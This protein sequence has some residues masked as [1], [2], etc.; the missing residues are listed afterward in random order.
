[1]LG[2]RGGADAVPD[3]TRLSVL[4]AV[5]YSDVKE[6]RAPGLSERSRGNS[7]PP[8]RFRWR[9][10][11]TPCPEAA[12]S[13]E[14]GYN[15]FVA[16]K[17]EQRKQDLARRHVSTGAMRA[18][19]A[20]E[21]ACAE[22]RRTASGLLQHDDRA[23]RVI[24][25][26]NA[27]RDLALRVVQGSPDAGRHECR[28]GC[29]FCCHTAVTA[30]PPEVMTV[31]NHLREHCT[32]EELAEIRRRIET[33]AESAS[34]MTCAE[35]TAASIRCALLTD[36]GNCRV[37]PV[38]PLACAGFLSTSRAA[39]EAE[40]HRVSGRAEVPVDRYAMLVCL[41][42]SHGLRDACREGG[43]DGEFYEL[44]HALRRIWD[45]PDA[46]KAWAAGQMLFASCP[47]ADTW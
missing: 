12:S 39:C 34:C 40:F 20:A 21:S 24:R 32:A 10:K 9:R 36:D 44:H 45:Q 29:A 31:F 4:P 5:G 7:I 35:Y 13:L 37:H 26:A 46:P 3:R 38:R 25:L 8:D 28:A 47:R 23:N 14:C 2:L 22:V 11:R 18:Q 1:M 41:G 17:R 19:A 27:A 43:L 42:A 30:A 16:R 33:N 15:G 6:L